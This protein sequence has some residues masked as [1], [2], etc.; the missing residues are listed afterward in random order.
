MKFEQLFCRLSNLVDSR[1]Q[2]GAAAAAD[3]HRL[4]LG[5]RSPAPDE[6]REMKTGGEAVVGVA[7][8]FGLWRL[9]A[10]AMLPERVCVCMC[11]YVCICVCVYVYVCVCVCVC[12]CDLSTS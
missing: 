8:C 1:S 9:G 6:E 11:V 7:A 4:S 10:V 5:A 3:Q 2:R 12:V